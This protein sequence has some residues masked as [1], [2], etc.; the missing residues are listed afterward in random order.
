M[1]PV[2][3]EGCKVLDRLTEGLTPENAHK[4]IDNNGPGSGIMAVVVE[5]IGEC[6]LGPKFSVSHY[7]EQNGDLMRDPEMVFF[8]SL[9]DGKY[10]PVMFRQDSLGICQESAV[11][12][13]NDVWIGV[14]HRQQADHATFAGTWMK[15]IKYQQRM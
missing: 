7:Y 8:K 13:E 14:R 1:K 15:N 4:R 6:N 12:D 11:F 10:Y 9:A 5:R 3:Q 2:N